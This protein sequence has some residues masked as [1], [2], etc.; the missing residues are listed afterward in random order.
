MNPHYAETAQR[1]QHRCEYCRAPEPVFNFPFEVEH[2]RPIS[3]GGKDT[4]SNRAL[5]CLSCNVYK[6]IYIQIEDPVSG[7]VFPL[8]HPRRDNWDVHF[9]IDKE[10]GVIVGLTGIGRATIACLRI[11]SDAQG[12]ARKEW[13]RL[14]VY[15]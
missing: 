1:A 15:P 11:N 2:I 8:F 12:I 3:L 4:S 10:T 13:I 7:D 6:G 9:Q 5:S 14:G